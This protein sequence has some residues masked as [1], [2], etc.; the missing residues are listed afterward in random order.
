M[1]C[2]TVTDIDLPGSMLRIGRN[3]F[4]ACTNLPG[5]FIPAAVN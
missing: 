4:M 1:G 2:R 3:A 5:M